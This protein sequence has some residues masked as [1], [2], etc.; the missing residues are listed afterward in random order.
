MV[1]RSTVNE[2]GGR[3][4]GNPWGTASAF[5]RDITDL[6]DVVPGDVVYLSNVG[7]EL[8]VAYR[9]GQVVRCDG[10][11]HLYVAGLASRRYTLGGASMMRFDGARRPLHDVEA[12]R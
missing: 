5:Y 2:P 11:T 8:M 9:V 12:E 7:G 10:L 1:S 6:E 4:D 3:P